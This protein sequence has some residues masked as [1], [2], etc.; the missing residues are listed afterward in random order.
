MVFAITTYPFTRSVYALPVNKMPG[1]CIMA[2]ECDIFS[3][4]VY[5]N[6]LNRHVHGGVFNQRF[7]ISPKTGVLY[8]CLSP[9]RQNMTSLGS[10]EK[11]IFVPY[12][13]KGLQFRSDYIGD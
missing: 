1:Y 8:A 7:V 6:M 4:E 13:L 9:K 5:S 12:S 2:K 3:F 11:G 10:G